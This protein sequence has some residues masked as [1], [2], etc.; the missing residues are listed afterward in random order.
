MAHD[1]FGQ[2]RLWCMANMAH[3]KGPCL[4]RAHY[5]IYTYSSFTCTCY[6]QKKKVTHYEKNLKKIGDTHIWVVHIC[7]KIRNEKIISVLCEKKTKLVFSKLCFRSHSNNWF[8]LF[9]TEHGKFLLISKFYKVVENSYM[10][11]SNFFQYFYNFLLFFIFLKIIGAS[12]QFLFWFG[13]KVCC[14]PT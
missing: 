13:L 7:A 6:F 12:T 5:C 4:G 1:S 3:A 2:S 14:E 10:F 11:V 8:C 9:C